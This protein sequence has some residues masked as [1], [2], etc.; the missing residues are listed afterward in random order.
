METGRKYQRG[1]SI[2]TETNEIGILGE[3]AVNL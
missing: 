1:P 2:A 3:I